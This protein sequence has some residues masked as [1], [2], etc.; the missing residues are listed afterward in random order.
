VPSAGVPNQSPFFIVGND[1]SGTTVLRLVVDR[2]REASVPPESMFLVDFAPVRR[3]GNLA[4]PE[5]AD[6]FLTQVWSH[7][8]V[9]LWKLRDDPPPLPAGLDHAEAYRFIVESPY[10]AYAGAQ[11]KER[12]GDKT[13]SYL[14]A[15]DELLAVWPDARIVVLVRDGRDVA[16]SIM[17]VPFGPNNVWAAARWWAQGIRAGRE[18]ALK[19]PGQILTVRYE[20]LVADP[21]EQARRV[22]EHLGLA[23]HE[24]MLA[25]ERSDSDKIVEDQADWFTN[26]WAGINES[27]VGRWRHQLNAR[28]QEVFAAVAGEELAV[29]GYEIESPG[30]V[31]SVPRRR[32]VPYALH[33]AVLRGV[34][35][36][37]LRL[38]RERGREVRYVFSRKVRRV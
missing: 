35:F 22:C 1:R 11:G 30:R 2:S 19:S 33:D 5:E 15:L 3:R 26:V 23:F 36:V 20:D 4:S 34:N 7:P 38:L 27:A 28:E 13:P 10:R 9:K 31:A 18:A 16:L 25:I 8:K 21:G 14:H 12:F 29:L 37:R 24:D 17:R 6:R 32:A